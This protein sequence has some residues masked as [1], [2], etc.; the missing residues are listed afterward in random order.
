MDREEIDKKVENESRELSKRIMTLFL[1][2]CPSF[3]VSARALAKTFAATLAGCHKTRG[4]EFAH[5]FVEE[6]FS[7]MSKECHRLGLEVGIELFKKLP[8][9]G[10]RDAARPE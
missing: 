10:G 3:P 9:K 6:F 7:T 5:K 4:G 8:E 1:A 2:L